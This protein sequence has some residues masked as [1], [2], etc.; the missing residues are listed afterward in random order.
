MKD[1]KTLNSITLTNGTIKDLT[2]DYESYNIRGSVSFHQ[3]IHTKKI[4]THGH[5]SF[6]FDVKADSFKNSGSC[7]LKE[8]CSIKEIINK[9]NLKINSG[10]TTNLISTGNLTVEQIIQSEKMN[11]IGIV[12]AKEINSKKFQLKLSGKSVI[13]RLIAD[14]IFV[15]KGKVTFPL[16]R[17][18]LICNYIKGENLRLSYTDAEVVEGETVVVG[19]GCNI[20]TLSYTKNYTVSSNSKVQHIIRREG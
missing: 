10:E 4:S 14:E 9:G 17:K 20:K 5:S 19:E 8:H 6:H 13:E 12:Q 7:V 3:E 11:L 15:E 2:T 18:K 16:L 1:K